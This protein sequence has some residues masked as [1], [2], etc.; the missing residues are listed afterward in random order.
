MSD[1]VMP[2]N[3]WTRY[4]KPLAAGVLCILPTECSA[5]IADNQS[6][7]ISCMIVSALITT[8][9]IFKG[10]YWLGHQIDEISKMA[11]KAR[12]QRLARSARLLGVSG[13]SAIGLITT[14]AI[15]GNGVAVTYTNYHDR[16]QCGVKAP[17]RA[18]A[19]ACQRYWDSYQK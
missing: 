18:Q 4:Q 19:H 1:T 17:T 10:A 3:S 13:V 8:P 6:N 9:L 15:V 16:Q 2:S 11:T 5:M 14:P 7:N 12:L